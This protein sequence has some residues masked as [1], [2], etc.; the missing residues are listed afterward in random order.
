MCVYVCT[1]ERAC[2]CVKCDTLSCL[3]HVPVRSNN[4][5][6]LHIEA[7]SNPVILHL[8]IALQYM[9]QN[10]LRGHQNEQGWEQKTHSYPPLSHNH[11]STICQFCY[12]LKPAQIGIQP[13]CLSVS[14]SLLIQGCIFLPGKDPPFSTLEAHLF[15]PPSATFSSQGLSLCP[16]VSLSFL[17]AALWNSLSGFG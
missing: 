17:E 5:A 15:L 9:G 11:K 8:S 7:P 2:V 4:L 16:L 13:T 6:L 1:C 12:S 3:H 10:H 14:I